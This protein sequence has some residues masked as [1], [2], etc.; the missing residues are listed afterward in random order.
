MQD[1]KRELH[2]LLGQ[3]VSIV[4]QAMLGRRSDTLRLHTS[5][6]ILTKAEEHK[7]ELLLCHRPGESTNCP[8]LGY[9][10]FA[11][12]LCQLL[13]KG[14]PPVQHM[15]QDQWSGFYVTERRQESSMLVHQTYAHFGPV[16]RGS[17]NAVFSLTAISSCEQTQSRRNWPEH[18]C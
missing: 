10:F 1:C 6:R 18:R 13:V 4:M 8:A 2:D 17:V 3:E 12:G 15:Q 14:P 7:C 16:S 5:V 11:E 9:F